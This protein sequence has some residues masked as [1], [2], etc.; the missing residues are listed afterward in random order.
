[1]DT[2]DWPFKK[3]NF[4]NRFDTTVWSDVGYRNDDIVV[5]SY[6]KVGAGQE[7]FKI[8]R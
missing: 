6:A 1:M 8:L 2:N 5:A 4:A 3:R 7:R